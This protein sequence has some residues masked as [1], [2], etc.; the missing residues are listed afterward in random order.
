MM[1]AVS[2]VAICFYYYLSQISRSAAYAIGA[3]WLAFVIH[4]LV[5]WAIWVMNM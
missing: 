2:F 1:K 3:L 5:S 4:K